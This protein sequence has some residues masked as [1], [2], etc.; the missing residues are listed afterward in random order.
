MVDRY[1]TWYENA[2]DDWKEDGFLRDNRPAAV[3]VLYGQDQKIAAQSGQALVDEARQWKE[4]RDYTQLRA[5]Y[6]ALATD[7]E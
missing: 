5:I 7:V 1:P 6:I 2:P 4:D 3:S